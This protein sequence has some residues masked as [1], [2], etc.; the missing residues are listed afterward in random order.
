MN[1][2][3]EDVC[4]RLAEAGWLAIAPHLFHRTGDP[5]LGYDDF[6]KIGPH[7]EALTPGTI[8]EDIDAALAV[9]VADGFGSARKKCRKH[10]VFELEGQ[11]FVLPDSFGFDGFPGGFHS[12][13]RVQSRPE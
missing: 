7:F 2:H 9:A 5:K 8:L 10:K 3:I 1:D 11:V 13:Q 12:T 6:S 4:S